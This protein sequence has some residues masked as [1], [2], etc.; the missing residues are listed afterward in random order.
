[1][2]IKLNSLGVRLAIALV[3]MVVLPTIITGWMAYNTM[4]ETIRSERIK[5]V[6]QV[7]NSKHDQL[8]AVNK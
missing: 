8:G 4:F 1:M 2:A 3:L 5:D 7:A 6:G